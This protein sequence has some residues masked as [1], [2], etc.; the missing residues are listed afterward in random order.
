M[1]IVSGAYLKQVLLSDIRQFVQKNPFLTI[2][3]M[4]SNQQLLQHMY[5]IEGFQ[6][7][8][9]V[10]S[11][12]EMLMVNFHAG[13]SRKR[14]KTGGETSVTI[15]LKPFFEELLGVQE[16]QSIL[17]ADEDEGEDPCLT[18][19]YRNGSFVFKCELG[20]VREDLNQN[21]DRE[22]HYIQLA[23]DILKLSSKSRLFAEKW[24]TMLYEHADKTE[25]NGVNLLLT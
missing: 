4:S 17:Y 10:M 18:I 15:A 16:L 1:F 11:G 19:G 14:L 24:I 13:S 23:V 6:V 8:K 21:E 20:G 25:C 5:Y 3:I 12:K 2:V 7:R 9:S 22:K